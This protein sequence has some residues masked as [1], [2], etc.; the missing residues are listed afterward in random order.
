MPNP[1]HLPNPF[2]ATSPKAVEEFEE[3]NGLNLPEPYKQYLISADCVEKLR[4]RA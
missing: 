3:R 2:G 4:F 1:I